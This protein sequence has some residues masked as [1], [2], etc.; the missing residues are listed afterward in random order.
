MGASS[1]GPTVRATM[2]SSLIMTSMVKVFTSGPTVGSSMAS[3]SGTGCMGLGYSR[4]STTALTRENT[5]TIKKTAMASSSG[6]MDESTRDNGRQESNTEQAPI[7][8]GARR[9]KAN[10]KTAGVCVGIPTSQK[11]HQRQHNDVG[12]TL[13]V[14]RAC[15]VDNEE[16]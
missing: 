2:A 10:G 16:T 3:G 8:H 11:V 5:K 7:Q 6:P 4:G 14:G 9:D 1:L 13:D 15:G 12:S